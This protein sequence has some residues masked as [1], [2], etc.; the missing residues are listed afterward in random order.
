M[1]QYLKERIVDEIDDANA[2]MAKAV[3]HKGT[4][5][6]ETFMTLAKQESQHANML[7]DMFRRKEK[8]EDMANK[9]YSAM[10]KEILDK[11]ADGMVKFE[12]MKKVYMMK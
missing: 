11:F 3:E 7:Y 9:D 8:P 5:C 1:L 12:A 2:Y 10:L 6:G 4:L